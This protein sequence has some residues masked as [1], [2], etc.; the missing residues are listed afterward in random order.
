[1]IEAQIRKWDCIVEDWKE[2]KKKR[3]HFWEATIKIEEKAREIFVSGIKDNRAILPGC[4]E[5][6]ILVHPYSYLNI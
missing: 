6:H 4:P 2:A 1:M 5:G 3:P